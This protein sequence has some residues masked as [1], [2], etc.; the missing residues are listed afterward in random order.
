MIT[1]HTWSYPGKV[2]G[3]GGHIIQQILEKARLNNIKVIGDDEA[4]E[5]NLSV[6]SG[7]SVLSTTIT[8]STLCSHIIHIH[9][10]TCTCIY[11]NV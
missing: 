7:V 11:L 2:I 6:Q 4:K 8:L 9:I 1:V 3:R 10:H 5:R